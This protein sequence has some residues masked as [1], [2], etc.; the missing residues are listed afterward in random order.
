MNVI[1]FKCPNCWTEYTIDAK[2]Q[3]V[4]DK[5]IE[6]GYCKFCKRKDPKIPTT[7]E[8]D[9]LLTLE[10]MRTRFEV[11]TQCG[12]CSAWNRM[13]KGT[14]PPCTNCGSTEYD[15]ESMRSVRSWNPTL[16]TKRKKTKSKSDKLS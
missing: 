7:A 4:V 12:S 10:D 3:K 14:S 16:G 2:Y 1:T 8:M 15:N 9:K 11:M 6:L 13:D 5:Q